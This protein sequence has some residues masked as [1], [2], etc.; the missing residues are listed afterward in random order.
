MNVQGLN[1]WMG[2][3]DNDALELVSSEGYDPT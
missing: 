2:S 1:L 3:N